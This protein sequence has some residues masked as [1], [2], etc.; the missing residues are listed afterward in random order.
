M[1]SK[2]INKFNFE[3]IQEDTGHGVLT[4]TDILISGGSSP[5]REVQEIMRVHDYDNS[6]DE[7]MGGTKEEVFK[8][9]SVEGL[10][11]TFNILGLY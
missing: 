6:E 7:L 5:S 1:K 9:T 8:S 2:L 3:A 11:I 4:G 10:I